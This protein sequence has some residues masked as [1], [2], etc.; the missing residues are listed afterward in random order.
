MKSI[1]VGRDFSGQL[2]GGHILNVG[3]CPGKDNCPHERSEAER[4]REFEKLT[5]IA[6]SAS[7]RRAFEYLLDSGEF[8]YKQLCLAWRRGNLAWDFEAGELRPDVSSIEFYGGW[9][10]M[11]AGGF[12]AIFGL[13]LMAMHGSAPWT[14]QDVADV[15]KL[16][17]PGVLVPMAASYNVRPNSIARRVKPHLREYYA[18]PH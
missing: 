11:L 13:A 12:F 17:L 5:G 15:V 3:I 7:A 4:Q 8:N 18:Q 6:C 2:A 16:L 9:L 1:D 14:M 10:T